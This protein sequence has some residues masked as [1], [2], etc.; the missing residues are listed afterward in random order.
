[1]MN[2]NKHLVYDGLHPLAIELR[3][4]K[5]KGL[6]LAYM[7]DM[8]DSM[9]RYRFN[10]GYGASLIKNF[11]SFGL[12]E[13]AVIKFEPVYKNRLPKSKRLRKKYYK[14]YPSY[15][16]IETELFYDVKRYDPKR[17]EELNNDLTIIKHF[18]AGQY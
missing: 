6:K 4:A 17:L 2:L 1:M 5:A 14:K 13:L 7:E 11:A 15:H 3:Q 9:K 18:K 8:G 10:N 12:W 16:L